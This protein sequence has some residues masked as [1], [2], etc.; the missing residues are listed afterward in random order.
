MDASLINTGSDVF[1]QTRSAH[2]HG[3][4]RTAAEPTQAWPARWGQIGAR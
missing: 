1:N 3:S 2:Q 4:G